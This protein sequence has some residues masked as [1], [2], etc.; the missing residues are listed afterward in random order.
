MD[1]VGDRA[2]RVLV[3]TKAEK[4]YAILDARDD[5]AYDIA[6]HTGSISDRLS[7]AQLIIIDYEDVIPFPFSER[8]IREEIYDSG[9][10]ECR[11][12][13][14]VGSPDDYLGGLAMN[15]P[16]TMLSLPKS[17]CIA[18]VS[19]SGGAGRTTL[20]LDTAFHYA[21]IVNGGGDRR[22]KSDSAFSGWL[23]PMLVE[24]T[25]GTSSLIALTGVEMPALMQLAT[26]PDTNMQRYRDV[27]F[28]PMDYENVRVLAVDL[29]DRYFEREM[30]KHSLTVIEGIWP[31][32][33]AK[34]LADKVDLWLVVACERPDTM[35]NAQRLYDELAAQY[36]EENVWLLQNR[37]K[38]VDEPVNNDIKWNI[39]LPAIQR[40]D[41][42]KGEL[43]KI[44]LSRVFAPLWKEYTKPKKSG[45]FS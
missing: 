35:Q 17:Y 4:V 9:V 36:Q 12:D 10:Y 42:Y 40:P 38:D 15:K 21:S 34:A 5:I 7:G 33:Q 45:F 30:A 16:G 29:L 25:F 39:R 22:R 23:P 31:H 2:I 37:V 6:L 43:G 24:M 14:F 18:L 26:D 1:A 3:S 41:D 32:S 13:D 27:D 19:Y 11:S 8:E 20:A 28:V 44:I